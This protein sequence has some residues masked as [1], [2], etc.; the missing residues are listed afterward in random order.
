MF[1]GEAL[2]T[3]CTSVR[4]APNEWVVE[5]PCKGLQCRQVTEGA[6]KACAKV[7]ERSHHVE[8]G[9]KCCDH[10]NMSQ[11]RG[12]WGRWRRLQ[13]VDSAILFSLKTQKDI[14]GGKLRVLEFRVVSSHCITWF[15]SLSR[16][17][18]EQA[19]HLMW[20]VQKPRWQ[21]PVCTGKS[22]PAPRP[23][24]LPRTTTEFLLFMCFK[25][26]IYF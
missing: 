2:E 21:K 24:S 20:V 6:R 13:A 22:P 3:A 25:C 16:W 19:M 7:R 5:Q 17:L 10:V 9:M 12:S 23:H 14:M 15:W 8:G 18:F 4:G 11:I 26:F 1:G